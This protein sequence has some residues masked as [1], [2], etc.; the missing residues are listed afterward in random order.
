MKSSPN[1]LPLSLTR[2]GIP[3]IIPPNHRAMIRRRDSKADRLVKWY[4]SLF[5]FSKVITLATKVKKS[6]FQ[7]IITP[8]SDID[9]VVELVGSIKG[10]FNSLVSRYVPGI[11]TIPLEQGFRF[12]PTWKTVPTHSLLRSH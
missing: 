5:S 10:V 1:S 2:T 7:S 3:L 12:V 4:L 6:T 9:A 8:V 11:T